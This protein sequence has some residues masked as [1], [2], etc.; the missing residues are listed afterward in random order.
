MVERAAIMEFDVGLRRPEA[1][2]QAR[3]LMRVYRV[4]VAM[5]DEPARWC[6]LLAPGC[7]ITQAQRA[8]VAQFGAARVL[9]VR[10]A[11][12]V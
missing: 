8:A 2:Q 6:T 1:E 7:D 11:D 3:S 9:E 4:L 10:E 12:H 5:D